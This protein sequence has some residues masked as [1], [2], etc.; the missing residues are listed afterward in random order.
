MRGTGND[1][2]RGFRKRARQPSRRGDRSQRVAIAAD[3]Q[4]RLRDCAHFAANV[5]RR[6][7]LERVAQRLLRRFTA[8]K[9]L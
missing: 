1:H 9:Q 7:Q 3:D 8:C 2:Q 4:R 5:A 6:Y